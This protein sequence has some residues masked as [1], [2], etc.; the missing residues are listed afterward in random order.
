[1]FESAYRALGFVS[2]FARKEFSRTVLVSKIEACIYHGYICLRFLSD[3]TN[4]VVPIDFSPISQRNYADQERFAYCIKNIGKQKY[5]HGGYASRRICKTYHL[6]YTCIQHCDIP[7]SQS[8]DY[9]PHIF[10]SYMSLSFRKAAAPFRKTMSS[11]P[12]TPYR[13]RT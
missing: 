1:M 9:L 8:L 5:T 3:L 4:D 12:A 7:Y 10:R 2:M 11:P 6:K 13:T